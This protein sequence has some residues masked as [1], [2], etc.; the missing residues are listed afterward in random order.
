MTD[1]ER[2]S[3]VEEEREEFHREVERKEE[4][5]RTSPGGRR[6]DDSVRVRRVRRGRMVHRRADAGRRR[7]GR[8]AGRSCRRRHSL[9]AVVDDGRAS[10]RHGQR[11][12]LDAKKVI[13]PRNRVR[14]RWLSKV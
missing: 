14:G 11:V 8:L 5:A 6:S 4:R 12:E 1:Q 2:R 10:H 13:F 7:A 3:A 9:H